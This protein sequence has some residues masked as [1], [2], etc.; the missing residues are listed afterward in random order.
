MWQYAVAAYES[1]KW[2]RAI[3]AL[4]RLTLAFPNHERIVEARLRL[5]QA[6]FHKGD[7][8]IAASEF[9]RIIERYPA[10]ELADDAALGVC[11]AYSG[12][13]PIPQRDQTYTERGITAC[14]N[15][16]RSY[17]GTESVARASPLRDSLRMKLAEKDYQNGDFYFRRHLYDSAIIY[18]QHVV[19][20]YPDTSVAP[21]ALLRLVEVY[22]RI[23]YAED[24][25]AARDRLL[26]DYPDSPEARRLVNADGAL[27]PRDA[28]RTA[29]RSARIRA[30][31]R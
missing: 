6:Y 28:G 23:G 7:Y 3:A 18:Y 13:S 11:E 26:R 21:K 31:S 24:A 20:R 10:H 5:G 12:L 27:P 14:E 22:T 17:P 30:A 29:G 2:S 16:M 19:E 8:L 9:E 25:E 1:G 4:E 15:V